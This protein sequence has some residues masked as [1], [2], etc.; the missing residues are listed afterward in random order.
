MKTQD[1]TSTEK[2]V[3]KKKKNTHIANHYSRQ[4][5][6]KKKYV[7]IATITVFTIILTSLL[8]YFLILRPEPTATI[9]TGEVIGVVAE[10]PDPEYDTFVV[11]I[12]VD[13]LG[14][15]INALEI[16]FTYD[17]EIVQI[18]SFD[19][20]N[21][22]ITIWIK[23]YPKFDNEI[24]EA[25]IGGGIP[26]PGLQGKANIIDMTVKV[27][28]KEEGKLI[29]TNRTRMLMNDGHGTSVPLELE[30]IEIGLKE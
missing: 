9:T 18:E 29:F 7:I 14:D 6:K 21:S 22:F 8:S 10:S 19:Q 12:I 28:K 30:D 26:N 1:N 5:I 25:V 4:S 17:P 11:P 24:G 2:I 15:S 3:K 16:F 13:T 23:D 27:K 20:Q